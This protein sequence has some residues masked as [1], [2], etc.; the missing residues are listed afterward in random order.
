[1]SW[2]W[3]GDEEVSWILMV[4]FAQV[5]VRGEDLVEA[6]DVIDNDT[7]APKCRLKG[8]IELPA[9]WIMAISRILRLNLLSVYGI[10]AMRNYE[11]LVEC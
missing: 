5:L 11:K 10:D 9:R 7:T 2:E 4:D 8:N 1:M 3:Y 6:A